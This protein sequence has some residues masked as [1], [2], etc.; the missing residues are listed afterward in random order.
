MAVRTRELR[1][2][3][4]SSQFEALGLNLGMHAGD[5]ATVLAAIPRLLDS[6]W[7]DN[8]RIREQLLVTQT[9]CLADVGRPEE[10]LRLLEQGFADA[11]ED[12]F[13]RGLY[14]H[15]RALVLFEAGRPQAVLA[16]AAGLLEHAQGDLTRMTLTAPV[17]A[18]S[19]LFEGVPGPELGELDRTL[20]M[21]RGVPDELAG[22]ALL[23]G[24][25]P[26]E[27]VGSFDRA[28]EL[29]APYHRRGE[30]RCRW[31]AGEALRRGGRDGEAV[32]RLQAVRERVRAH[33]MSSLDARVGRSL[34]SLGVRDL[35]RNR[36]GTA[37]LSAREREVLDLV[38]LGLPDATIATRLGISA[39]TVET[40]VA[41]ARRKLGATTRRQAVALLSGPDVDG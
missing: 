9:V 5:Y 1:L 2:L 8:L 27:A 41:S 19:A 18:W 12:R 38:A 29:W 20:R 39:R 16:E 35:P 37:G 23:R 3:E 22:I 24:A 7:R 40:H 11:P 34:R 32:E 17:F 6:P 28:A 21:L 15:A 36:A 10:A 13:G 33:G 14:H 25:S 26:V 31:A 30:L 4:W